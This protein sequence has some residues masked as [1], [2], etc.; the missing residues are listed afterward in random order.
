VNNRN[1][2]SKRN[3][4]VAKF[5]DGAVQ[6]DCRLRAVGRPASI[7]GT[8]IFTCDVLIVISLGQGSG[9]RIRAKNRQTSP[10]GMSSYTM[11][12]PSVPAL[13]ISSLHFYS[14]S[15]CAGKY[16]PLLVTVF[17]VIMTML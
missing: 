13:F 3:A 16:N 2:R 15:L 10:S 14:D 7:S 11:L 8:S 4:R 12:F 9:I 6:C 5:L 1:P 17:V